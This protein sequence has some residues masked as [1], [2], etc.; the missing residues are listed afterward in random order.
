MIGFELGCVSAIDSDGQTI[1]I[2]DAHRSDDGKRVN[3]DRIVVHG[4]AEI[5]DASWPDYL[6]SG[7]Q[8]PY[9]ESDFV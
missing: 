7:N 8:K 9:S 5:V 1:W 2:A 6:P 4:R 3:S